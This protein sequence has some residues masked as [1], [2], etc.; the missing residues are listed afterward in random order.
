MEQQEQ[1]HERDVQEDPE[2]VHALQGTDP[3][4]IARAQA[5]TS[6]RVRQVG[7]PSPFRLMWPP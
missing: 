6:G 3:D 4:R 7:P 1:R 5:R 2:V